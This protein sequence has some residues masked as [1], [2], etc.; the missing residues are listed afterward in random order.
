MI[1]R[2]KTSICVVKKTRLII[3]QFTF[4]KRFLFVSVITV[5]LNAIIKKK[6]HKIDV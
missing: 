5:Y 3:R 1:L 2:L 4:L 6:P